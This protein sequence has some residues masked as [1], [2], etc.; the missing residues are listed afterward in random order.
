VTVIA[1]IET[2]QKLQGMINNGV[3]TFSVDDTTLRFT[4]SIEQDIKNW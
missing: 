4:I 3:L 2:P 1:T